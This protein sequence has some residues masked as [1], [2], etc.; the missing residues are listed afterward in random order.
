MNRK[1]IFQGSAGEALGEEW[2][3]N[4]PTVADAFK[5]VHANSPKKYRDYFEQDLEAEFSV[6]L[7]GEALGEAELLLNNLKGEDIVVTPV[8][9]GSKLNAVEKILMAVVLIVIAI[10]MPE[11]LPEAAMEAGAWGSTLQAAAFSMGFNMAL[12]GIT[13]LMM[14]D[15]SNDKEEEGAMFG[16][17]AQTIKHGQPVPLCYGKMMVGGT[18]ITFGFGVN[19]LEPTNGLVYGSDSPGAWDGEIYSHHGNLKDGDNGGYDG[20][21]Y[22]GDDGTWEDY[23][24]L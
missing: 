24:E 22:D 17:P 20:G 19:K 4:A 16:G 5:I 10:Y 8:P 21:G 13:E 14:D 3:V 1:L 12:A 6:K 18:P 9:K 15:P 2:T 23:D 11:F 7:A